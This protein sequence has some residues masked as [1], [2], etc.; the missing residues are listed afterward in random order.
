MLLRSA[1]PCIAAAR[2][3]GEPRCRRSRDGAIPWRSP[4]CDGQPAVPIPISRWDY[5]FTPTGTGCEVSES[6][7]DHRP[8]ALKLLFRPLFGDR[9]PRNVHGIRTTLARLQSAAE[10]LDYMAG[11]PAPVLGDVNGNGVTDINDYTVIRNNFNQPGNKSQGDLTGDGVV[12]FP[13]FRF[14]KNYRTDAAIA[15]A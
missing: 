12:S 3:I 1:T 9:A 15:S 8:A 2:R 4:S 7:T 13:D 5:R 10:A 6:W 11:L 14:W